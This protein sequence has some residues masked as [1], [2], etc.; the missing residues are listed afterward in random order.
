MGP[1]PTGAGAGGGSSATSAATLAAAKAARVE[2]KAA[3]DLLTKEGE[4]RE[5]VNKGT[6]EYFKLLKDITKYQ[7]Q[8]DFLTKERDK[9]QKKA[10]Q[11]AT[12]TNAAE[13]TAAKETVKMLNDKID[14]LGK[15][16]DSYVGIAKEAN[17]A[18]MATKAMFNGVM[19]IPGM[20]EKAYGFIKTSGLFDMDKAMKKAALEMG[21][22]SNQTASFRKG[23]FDSVT[24]TGK[25]NSSTL[26]IGVG[27]EELSGMQADYSTN[28]GTMATFSD[29][30]NQAMAEL[31]KGTS[32][33]AE[34]AS[35]MAS[36]FGNLGK[37]VEDTASFVNNVLDDSHKL[38][39]NASKVLK[40]ISS[41]IGL[42]NRYNFKGGVDGL[43]KMAEN[44]TKLGVSMDLVGPMA[45]KLFDIEGA[46]E[47]SAQLQV[48]G[49]EWAKLADPF[50]L[51]YMARND[52]EGL[53]KAVI[54]ATKSTAQFNKTTGEF[55]I[56][57]LD[58]QRLRKVAEQT[59][60]NYEELAQS[61]KKA[62][63]YSAI[64][65]QIKMKVDP[66]TKTFIEGMSTLDKNGKASITVNGDTKLVSALTDADNRTLKEQA[67]QKES[68]KD[69]AKDAINFDDA[70]TNTLNLF[71]TAMLPIVDGINSTLLPMITN[72]FAD[73][74]FKQNLVTLGQKI[75]NFVAGI[76]NV[77]SVVGK[78]ITTLG[79]TGT[80]AT[81][82]GVKGLLSAAAWIGNGL[83]LAKG[84]KMG[85]AGGVGGAAG[86]GAA[87]GG[88]GYSAGRIGMGALG[89][90]GI[91]AISALGADSVA[92]GAGNIIGGA[93]G[94]ALLSFIPVVGTMLGGY[95]GSQLGGWVG[96]KIGGGGTTTT[97]EISDG[98]IGSPVHDG[99]F[100]GMSDDFSKGL[101]SD[102]SKGRG[103]IQGGQITPIDNKDDLIAAKPNGIVDSA[104][105][106]GSNSNVNITF[107]ELTFGG[108]I[109]LKT[110][111][112]SKDVDFTQGL[113]SDQDFLRSLTKLVHIEASKAINGGKFSGQPA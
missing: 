54:D 12:A 30:A 105:K 65:S 39:L 15:I 104:M 79:P 84:F 4:M 81:V 23:I 64:D 106:S 3:F 20:L 77:L 11:A 51:M 14:T 112:G 100:P 46:V 5:R 45:D 85:T 34:G 24:G 26:E 75:G 62:A 87:K 95:I 8:I 58:M 107:G 90:A 7:K 10:S 31:A 83:D 76:G 99:K 21:V 9:Q 35:K 25:L 18:A 19:K 49:G 74:A 42:M 108:S 82:L 101:G 98:I 56:S 93:A 36:D 50:K 92:E 68:L 72:I 53:Q 44:A 71:K 111:G 28:L 88:F 66:D 110:P 16:K 80:I 59:G 55:D 29:S 73:K 70:L 33:G 69:R 91:G 2:A 6:E 32:L 109:V 86:G 17:L 89:G 102:F 67:A 97:N 96:K 38:G 60:L 63:K 22:L 47:M 48:L 103:V 13:I 41:S 113:L 94:A 27:L 57:A 52:M 40:N 78:V 37:S 1:T 43:A 61:A